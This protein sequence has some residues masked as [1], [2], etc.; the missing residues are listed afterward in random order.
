MQR[1]SVITIH[2]PDD[3]ESEVRRASAEADVSVSAW[4]TDAVKQRLAKLPSREVIALFGMF[5]DL[6][7]P[8]RRES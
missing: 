1:M 6:E 4:M 3:L 8:T 7:L 5:P 2:L